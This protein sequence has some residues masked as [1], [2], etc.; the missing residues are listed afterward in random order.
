MPEATKYAHSEENE[1]AERIRGGW[2]HLP[3]LPNLP[4]LPT[5]GTCSASATTDQARE[6]HVGVPQSRYCTVGFLTPVITRELLF[7]EA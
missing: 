2:R 3:N 4:N 6:R 7:M 1:S 5:S